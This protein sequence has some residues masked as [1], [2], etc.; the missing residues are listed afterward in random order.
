MSINLI[1][2]GKLLMGLILLWHNR[3]KHQIFVVEF[4]IICLQKLFKG[5]SVDGKTCDVPTGIT[6]FRII[7]FP[8]IASGHD[9]ACL[10]LTGKFPDPVV[11]LR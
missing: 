7:D 1:C 9:K 8:Q 3:R 6:K 5:Q 4:F 10:E 2:L 11:N